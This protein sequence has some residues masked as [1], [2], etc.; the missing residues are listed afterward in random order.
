MGKAKLTGRKASS[1]G[2]DLFGSVGNGR[3]RILILPRQLS[4]EAASNFLKGSKQDRAY[5]IIKIWADLEQNGHLNKKETALDAGFLHE[6]LGEALGYRTIT[7]SPDSYDLERNFSVP[8]NGTADGALG[9]FGTGRAPHA[10]ATVELKGAVTDLDRDRFNGRTAVQQCWDYL[11]FLPNCPWGI[12]SN[13]T[14]IRLYHRDKT[15][16][17]YHE[18]HLRELRN[19]DRFN[20][21]YC[22]F[23]RGAFLPS[24]LGQEP[25]AIR[26]LR[27]TDTQRYEVGDKLY[28][29]YSDNRY[30][31]IQHLH[32]TLGK[33]L[34]AAIHI[35][36]KLLDRIIFIAFC[37]DRDLLPEKIIESAWSTS[38]LFRKAANQRWRNFLELF[39]AVDHGNGD[40]N[41]IEKGYNGG[42][43][44][45]DPEVDE[46]QLDDESARFFKSIGTYDFRDEINVE[47]LGRLF[48]KSVGELEKLRIGGLFGGNG[49]V[50]EP[51]M[52]KS[53]ER[54][55]FGT[56]YTP[57]DFTKFIV[58]ETIGT[59]VRERL[60]AVLDAHKI[61]AQ[62]LNVDKPSAR[63]A[64]YWKDSLLALRSIKICDP[65]CGSGAFLIQAYDFL[66][67]EYRNVVQNI[68]FHFERNPPVTLLDVPDLIVTENL[69]GVDV[70]EQAV[71][72]TQLA[73]WIRT[74]RQGRTLADLSKNIVWGNSLVTDPAVHPKAMNWRQTFPAVF[75]RTEQGFDC[76]IG[77]PPW[78]RMKVQE[79]E[80]FAFSAPKIAEA[81]SAAKRKQLIVQLEKKNP[82]LFQQY[83]EAKN[84][85][86]QTLAH[87]R[88]SGE[89]PLT[90]V[91]DINTYMLF[92]EL[93]RKIVAPS[94]RV[95]LLVPSGIATDN[96]TRDFF[97]DVMASK[98]LIKLY[99]FENRRLIF[100]DVDGRFKFCIL[101]LAGSALKNEDAD[102]VFFAHSMEDLDE[103]KKHIALSN[104]DIALVNP[105]TRTC[106]IFRTRR[107]ADLTE[108][109]YRRVPVLIDKSR[110]E[111]G[112]PWGIK[113]VRMFD[114]TNDAELFQSPEQLKKKGFK[115]V[116]N[117]WT[118]GKRRYL[119]LYE[120]KMVQAYDHRAASV[121]ID[122]ANWMRQGQTEETSLVSHQNPEF[123][124]QP[125]WWVEEQKIVSARGGVSR[126]GYLA[127][128]DVTSATNQRT[129]IAAFIPNVAVVNSAPLILTGEEVTP[130]QAACLLANLNALPLDFV[131]RQKVG[132]LHLNFFI[133]EQFPIFPP[134]RYAERCPWNKRQT[135]EKWISDRT[136]KLTCTA[137]D[138]KPLADA[139][140][141]DPPIHKW[142]PT[143]RAKLMAE[144]DAAYFVLYGIERDEVEYIMST[145]QGLRDA[146]P[147][148]P[149]ATRQA[150]MILAEYD[151][152]LK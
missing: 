137:N 40:P 11:K 123:V 107:D 147:L 58:R 143:E 26:L 86:E 49:D 45:F 128:K 78:E 32:H 111:G 12:V 114:Q 29:E 65:A 4:E 6:V 109:I 59:I 90:A 35:A 131:A 41:G 33:P 95:G 142:N 16:L 130:R 25:R 85:A 88:T 126:A 54:K 136:M 44:R 66:E 87:V 99:D 121:V 50:P 149:G 76:A 69:Y 133:V 100:P 145:F 61:K 141:F 19:R 81:V 48:E 68:E 138:M 118:K 21:F 148:L 30:Q 101:V 108:S 2:P 103:K 73:L 151:R 55:R 70:M 135:L 104:A 79:R 34:P 67:E 56:F 60:D 93:A 146:Q 150:D 47:V 134:D 127:I 7:Q 43:F 42:L 105:N 102:F 82:E 15:P 152:L 98:S 36:Q 83:E 31:L 94:G 77:N 84:T 72:I 80:F 24:P 140:G 91:G 115:H 113:F 129:V 122:E 75:E 8:G 74:A 139:A 18:F 63:L 97:A 71:E 46:L 106:P 38:P 110:E 20:E 13:F 119:P 112:N 22:L 23:E 117:C 89:F 17:S 144:L 51:A 37:Q 120:A 28:Q 64:A 96:T 5:E 132:G 39:R 52:P 57:P 10:V 27:T 1:N 124:A 14:T 3:R 62:E 53:A 125:R 9:E 92:A 116:G